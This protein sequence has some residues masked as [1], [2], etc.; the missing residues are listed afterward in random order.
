MSVTCKVNDVTLNFIPAS[1]YCYMVGYNLI[2][3][4]THPV[5]PAKEIL[6]SEA[7]ILEPMEPNDEV[8]A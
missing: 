7:K 3:H 2:R 4:K 1:I 6:R 8:T 5:K